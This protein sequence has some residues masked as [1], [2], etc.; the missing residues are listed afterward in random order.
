MSDTF[1]G[2]IV[3]KARSEVEAATLAEQLYWYAE[4]GVPFYNRYEGGYAVKGQVRQVSTADGPA[5]LEAQNRKLAARLAELEKQAEELGWKTRQ[6]VSRSA[7]VNALL[8][9]LTPTEHL[10]LIDRNIIREHPQLWAKED[11]IESG[12]NPAAQAFAA[13]LLERAAQK[14]EADGPDD[15]HVTLR[16]AEHCA[17]IVRSLIPK[18][19]ETSD[20]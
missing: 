13:Q 20:G 9:L 14:I 3:L 19:E 8:A 17:A 18:A 15:V 7:N 16:A 10:R 1:S 4:F 11:A 6:A 2:A 5:V 12:D